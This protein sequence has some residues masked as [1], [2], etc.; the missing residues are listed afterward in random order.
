MSA[1]VR[2]EVTSQVEEKNN[3]TAAA[4]APSLNAYNP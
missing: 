3:G 4:N 1:K 2:E